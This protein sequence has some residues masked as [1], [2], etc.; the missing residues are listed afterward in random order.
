MLTLF[1]GDH[2]AVVCQHDDLRMSL[3]H[4]ENLIL[5]GAGVTALHDSVSTDSGEV[6]SSAVPEREPGSPALQLDGEGGVQWRRPGDQ[7]AVTV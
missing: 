5:P 2:F 1:D 7:G 3:L 6:P 4:H